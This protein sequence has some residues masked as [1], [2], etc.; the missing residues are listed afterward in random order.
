MTCA[1][2]VATTC[3]VLVLVTAWAMTR[4]YIEP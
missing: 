2:Y 3:V 1:M 4:G